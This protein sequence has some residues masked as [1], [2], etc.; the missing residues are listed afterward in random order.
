MEIQV[1]ERAMIRPATQEDIDL[2]EE[3]LRDGDRAECEIFGPHKM[4]HQDIED[5]E[6]CWAIFGHNKLVGY[7]GVYIEPGQTILS[8]IRWL[9]F[10]STQAVDGMKIS[11]VKDSHAV[12]REI[13]RRTKGHVTR[14]VSMPMA[15][16]RGAVIWHERVLKMHRFKTVKIYNHEHI[17]YTIERKEVE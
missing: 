8:P 1:T 14:F 9:C 7:C 11:F 13:V 10:L 12:M 6:E 3:T 2:V 5:F 16:Y 4:W 17:I 15:D